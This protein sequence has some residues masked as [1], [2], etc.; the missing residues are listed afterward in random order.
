MGMTQVQLAKAVGL[1]SKSISAYECG[2]AV[3][4]LNTLIKLADALGVS[5][6]TLV[7]RGDIF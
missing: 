1:T 5:L 2:R 4:T 3:P 7:G 6:D